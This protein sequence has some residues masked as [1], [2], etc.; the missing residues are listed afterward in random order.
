MRKVL[1]SLMTKSAT[2]SSEFVVLTGDHGYALFDEIR[3][4]CPD[5][6]INV[7]MIEQAMVGISAGLSQMGVTPLVYGL[8]CF[9]PIRVIEQIKL[10]ICYSCLPVKIIGDGAGLVYSTLGSSHQCGED[11][12]CLRTLPHIQIY[13]PGDPEEMRICYIE[14]LK[15]KTPTYLRV[16]KCDNIAINK[17]PLNSTLPYFTNRNDNSKTCLVSTGSMLGIVNKLSKKFNVSHISVMKLKP[18]SS[19]LV[20]MLSTFDKLIFF[21]EHGRHGGLTSAVTELLIDHE[22]CIPKIQYFTL[23]QKFSEKCGS[24][25][26]ALSEHGISDEQLESGLSKLL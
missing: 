21:E 23:K 12:A 5:Q 11:I 1:S 15:E 24:H 18:L 25:Q 13:S 14:S 2:D 4:K 6:F 9:V 7:G 3:K 16:G 8:A 20:E 19:L 10:D 17:A 22:K 26:Y